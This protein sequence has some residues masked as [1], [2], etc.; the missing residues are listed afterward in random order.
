METI[1]EKP[2]DDLAV[3]EAAKRLEDLMSEYLSI[4]KVERESTMLEL[5]PEVRKKVM[6]LKKLQL[7]TIN[8]DAEFHRETY[9]LEKKYQSRHDG[10]YLKRKEI[11][12]GIYEPVE[13]DCKLPEHLCVEEMKNSVEFEGAEK[14]LGIPQ[15]WLTVIKNV[16]ELSSMIKES[17]E[18]ILKHLIE[19]RAISM[20]TSELSFNLEF[21]F[22]P[23][24]YFTNTILSK[25][26]LMK[27]SPDVEDPFSF[28]GPEIYKTI[29]CSIA[30]N[31][32]KNVTE[33]SVKK[34][35]TTMK[36]FKAESFF[37]FFNPPEL[38][39]GFSEENDKIEEYLENDFEIG[40]FLKE[41][42]VP[43]AVLYF[44]GEIDEDIST[45][46]ETESVDSNLRNFDEDEEAEPLEVLGV[47]G[48]GDN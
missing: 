11:V 27:C 12:N 15:F 35:D 42:V 16:S 1:V 31:A 33:K 21:H 25:T 20:P 29:G 4:K 41:R 48:D 32:G 43:R 18:P 40:H 36:N 26:Y 34:K 8:L 46:N 3:D 37:N 13:E 45:D 28:E 24:E 38:K 23:N 30:W 44:T 19:I 2:I 6:A 10:V 39:E 9:E 22:E 14:P 47:D 17:D 5:H 7:E